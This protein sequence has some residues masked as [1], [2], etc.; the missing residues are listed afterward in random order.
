MEA[1]LPKLMYQPAA[2]EPIISSK[3]IDFHFN[4]HLNGY[5]NNLLKL[6][7]GT[8]FEGLPVEEVVKKAPEGGILNNAGQVVN[9]V[10]YFNQFTDEPTQNGPSGKLL[11]KVNEKFGSFHKMKEEISTAA[12]TLFGSGWVWLTLNPNHQLEII[13]SPNGE[14]PLR[15][16]HQLLLTIDVW[17]HA[18]YLDYQN[19]RPDYIEAFWKIIDWKVIE[20]RFV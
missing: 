6:S 16:G 9:H 11:E 5:I 18:Y 19:R 8:E 13:K 1:K 15:Q 12:K 4:K 10:Y 20:K 2:L 3:T 17:E 14:N 7:E